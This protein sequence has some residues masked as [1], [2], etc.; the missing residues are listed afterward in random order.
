MPTPVNYDKAELRAFL[1]ALAIADPAD[2]AKLVT[3][4][5]EIFKA[6]MEFARN[7]TEDLKATKVAYRRLYDKE[8]RILNHNDELLKENAQLRQQAKELK[9]QHA[10]PSTSSK[11]TD[12]DCAEIAAPHPIYDHTHTAPNNVTPHWE[13][14]RYIHLSLEELQKIRPNASRTVLSN[15]QKSEA[16]QNPIARVRLTADEFTAL[17]AIRPIRK[18]KPRF[19]YMGV[20]KLAVAD[21]DRTNEGLQGYGYNPVAE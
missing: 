1:Q 19:K 18:G 2:F 8:T 3:N 12:K 5:M 9:I 4:N 17:E 7:T 13:A 11:P 20:K 16:N 6:T 14:H 10:S 15:F 21:A